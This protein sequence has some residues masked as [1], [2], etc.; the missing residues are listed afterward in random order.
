MAVAFVAIFAAKRTAFSAKSAVHA[1]FL[2]EPAPATLILRGDMR[3][4]PLARRGKSVRFIRNHVKPLP[5]KYFSSVFRKIMIV[6]MHPASTRRGVSRSSRTLEAGCGGREDV[7][8]RLRADE[9]IFSDGQAV[10]SR[11]PDAGDKPARFSQATGAN[12]PGARGEH[13][14]AVNTIAQ[15]MPVVPALP[16]VT[17]ACVFCCR[18]AMG[19]ATIR[20]SLRP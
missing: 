11:P 14:A 13:G 16:V 3:S 17:A 4:T 15:G 18:R 6:S 12:K 1:Y 8:A 7:S 10:W 9:G 19:A 5:Q 2:D 20:H